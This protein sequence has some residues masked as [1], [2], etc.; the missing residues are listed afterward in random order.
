MQCNFDARPVNYNLSL[1]NKKTGIL[2]S[3]ELGASQAATGRLVVMLSTAW[4]V[5][6]GLWGAE[7]TLGLQMGG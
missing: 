3:L 4:M 7:V 5:L 1:L 6:G 2:I